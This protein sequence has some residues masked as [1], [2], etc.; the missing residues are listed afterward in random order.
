MKRARIPK[1]MPGV[2][3][4]VARV[5]GLACAKALAD[6]FGGQRIFIP[7]SVGPDHRLVA[8]CSA[9]GAAA[10]SRT[11]GGDRIEIP[12][13]NFSGLKAFIASQRRAILSRTDDGESGAQIARS[14]KCSERTV[15]KVRS[16]KRQAKIQT[17]LF[18]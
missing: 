3:A 14:L 7:R 4:V 13:W 6:R 9:E 1:G 16:L 2:L 18:D 5:A 17:D 11:F 10:L 8:A 12:L 15:R